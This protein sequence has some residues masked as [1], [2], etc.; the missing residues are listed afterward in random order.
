MRCKLLID[1]HKCSNTDN[2][3]NIPNCS[4]ITYSPY[5]GLS[6]QT[7]LSRCQWCY[8]GSIACTTYAYSKQFERLINNHLTDLL[9]EIADVLTLLFFLIKSSTMIVFVTDGDVGVVTH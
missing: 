8:G 1:V 4:I 9:F 6:A 7:V 2:K 3:S 5:T